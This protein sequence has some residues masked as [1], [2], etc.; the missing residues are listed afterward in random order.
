[1]DHTRQLKGSLIIIGHTRRTVLMNM[2]Y[3]VCTVVYDNARPVIWSEN[4]IFSCFRETARR[5]VFPRHTANSNNLIMMLSIQMSTFTILSSAAQTEYFPTRVLV[6]KLNDYSVKYSPKTGSRQRTAAPGGRRHSKSMSRCRLLPSTP[7]IAIYYY[8][9][10]GKLSFHRP[11][12]GGRLSRPG[13]CT[14]DVMG[15]WWR[16]TRQ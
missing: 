3:W 16:H 12:K 6:D 15:C 2:H 7:T 5:S 14:E 9:S 13:Q 11:T 1:M 8:Y 10:A 4:I